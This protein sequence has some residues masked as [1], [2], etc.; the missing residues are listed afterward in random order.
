MPPRWQNIALDAGQVW[1]RR[2]P[3]RRVPA[4]RLVER[5]APFTWTVEVGRVRT[6]YGVQR[7]EPAGRRIVYGETTIRNN[8][9]PVEVR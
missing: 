6:L 3:G 8:Y 4:L 1:K 5:S 7:F 9:D 2:K